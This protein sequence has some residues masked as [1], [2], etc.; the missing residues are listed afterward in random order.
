[1]ETSMAYRKLSWL[2]TLPCLMLVACGGGGSSP[3]SDGGGGGAGGAADSG[4]GSGGGGGAAGGA[5]GGGSGGTTRPCSATLSGAVNATIDCSPAPDALFDSTS[6]AFTT[7][8]AGA[9]GTQFFNAAFV[10]AGDVHTG[11]FASTDATVQAGIMIVSGTA[12][13]GAGSGGKDP[14][15]GTFSLVINQTSVDMGI[16]GF[17]VIHGTL[18]A[19]VPAATST[20]AA[21][22]VTVHVTF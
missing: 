21:G 12:Q 3:G 6:N 8:F 11:T 14:P 4:G 20:G 1:M 10:I 2:A 13:W 9:Q 18:D 17:N 19:T 16:A 22:T 7:I 5:G 15:S